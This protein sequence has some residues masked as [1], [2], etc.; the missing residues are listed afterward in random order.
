MNLIPRSNLL[1][2]SRSPTEKLKA[3]SGIPPYAWL[4]VGV[5]R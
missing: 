5:T 2:Q 1:T 3:Y 4:A